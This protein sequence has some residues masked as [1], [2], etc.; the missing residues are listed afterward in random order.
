MINSSKPIK[1]GIIG[2]GAI[3]ERGYLPAVKLVSN[4]VLTHVID[5]DL[6]RAKSV[7]KYYDI[8]NFVAD[9]RSIFGKVDAVVV[10]TPPNSH[11]PIS[12]DCLNHGL[13]VLCEKPLASTIEEAER[14]IASSQRTCNHLAVGM[15]RRLSWSS[16]LLKKLMDKDFLG[17]IQRFDFEEGRQFNWP[18][19]TPHLFQHSKSGGVLA[20]TATHLFD[21]L[22][23]ILGSQSTQL[24]RYRDDGWSGVEANAVVE[25]ALKIGPRQVPGRVELS[26]TRELRNTMR[27]YGERGFLEA[28]VSGGSEVKYYPDNRE[29][30][31]VI[32]K[33]EG[34]RS[35]SFFEEL[36]VQ[37]SNF[38]NSIINSSQDYVTA[39][40]VLATISLI[41]ECRYSRE[42]IVHP[43][44]MKYLEPFFADKRDDQ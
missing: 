25:L 31:P 43:W 40:E 4:I 21:L 14:M 8:P 10:A 26:F 15:V 16:T 42:L 13:H 41:D 29:A 27:I 5:L 33:S 28:P 11:A 3:T 17:N 36:A 23:W 30:E 18:L 6:E 22:F 32:L 7:A 39:H 9:Y 44:E 12:I 34:A 1:L 2:C 24:T 35:R 19:R 38:A 37:L 20:D